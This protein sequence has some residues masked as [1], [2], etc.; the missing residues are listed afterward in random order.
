MDVRAS[1]SSSKKEI[2]LMSYTSILW[3]GL[4]DEISFAVAILLT[5]AEQRINLF[6]LVRAEAK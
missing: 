6:S 4:S 2:N 1:L 3:L 5:P